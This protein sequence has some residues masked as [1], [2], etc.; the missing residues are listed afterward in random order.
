MIN[1]VNKN[2]QTTTHLAIFKQPFLDAILDGRKTIESRFM[3]NRSVPY[4]KIRSG[5][6]VIM[7]ESGGLLV[8]EFKVKKVEDIELDSP[9]M[10]KY[11]KSFSEEICSNL[12]KSFW[13][14]RKNKR[15]VTLIWI[16]SLIR[17]VEPRECTEKPNRSMAGW[18]VLKD[19]DCNK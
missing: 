17:Y 14:S 10:V 7:K 3:V 1:I 11:C 5:D 15:Y 16:D 6:R 9:E 8:G 4:K 2:L 12:D 13:E 18:F 19:K